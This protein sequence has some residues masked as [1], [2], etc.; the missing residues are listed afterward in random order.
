MEWW[1]VAI[2][3]WIWSGGILILAIAVTQIAGVGPW[4][5]RAYSSFASCLGLLIIGGIARNDGARA[6]LLYGVPL[7]MIMVALGLY[8]AAVKTLQERLL[9]SKGHE[10]VDTTTGGRM[11]SESPSDRYDAKESLTAI[12]VFLSVSGAIFV[13][14]QP[15]RSEA[16]P[17]NLLWVVVPGLLAVVAYVVAA[18]SIRRGWSMRC[19]ELLEHSEMRRS[20]ESGRVTG[21]LVRF[22]LRRWL[23]NPQ[24]AKPSESHQ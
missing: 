11:Q 24:Q 20:L 15:Q 17:A 6:V 5:R 4:A 13:I 7:I 12:V 10:S 22:L 16:W 3:F 21:S 14:A 9:F 1:L 8:I 18:R 23:P 19:A 2:V